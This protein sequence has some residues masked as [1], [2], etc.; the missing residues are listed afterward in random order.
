MA[1]ITDAFSERKFF[2]YPSFGSIHL[3]LWH[4]FLIPLRLRGCGVDQSGW[5]QIGLIGHLRLATWATAPCPFVLVRR[6]PAKIS[7]REPRRLLAK[8]GYSP[9]RRFADVRL[10]TKQTLKETGAALA[11]LSS[12]RRYVCWRTDRSMSQCLNACLSLIHI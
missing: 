7:C 11:R 4:V 10:S 9:S 3:F 2:Y 8:N 1:A 5:R 6:D 12:V